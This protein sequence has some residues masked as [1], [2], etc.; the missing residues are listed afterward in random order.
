MRYSYWITFDEIEENAPAEPGLFQIRVRE[1]LLNYRK[2]K[3]AMF[4]YGFADN[5]IHGLLKFRNN[6]LRLLEINE[7]VLFVRWLLAEDT[8]ER[9]QNH[10]NYFLTNFGSMPL[11]NEMLLRKKSKQSNPK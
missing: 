7:D 11:G 5:L 10:L 3:S 8:E 4:Y 6:T 1:G 9:F 2:G